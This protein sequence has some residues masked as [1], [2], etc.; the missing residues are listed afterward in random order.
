MGA[1]IALHGDAVK[2]VAFAVDNCRAMHAAAVA[3]GAE[4]VRAPVEL[5][6]AADGSEGSGSVWVATIKTY[7]DCTH[8]FVERAAGFTGAFLPGFRSLAA[9]AAA[10]PLV[11]LTEPIGLSHV[12]HCV[13]NQPDLE[14]TPV[15]DWYERVLQFHRFWS[16]DDKMVHTEF[17]SLRSIVMV[18]YDAVVKMPINEPADGKR[19]SQ[20]QEYVEYHGGAGVQHI[21][22]R[23][24]DI[25]GAVRRL[26]AR[27]VQFL[28]IPAAYYK[29]LRERLAASKCVVKEDMDVIEQ[30]HILVDFDDNGYLLQLFTKPVEDRPTLFIEVIQRNN[31]E[32]F[33]AGNFGALFKSIE[34]EQ[35]RRGNL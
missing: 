31:H 12:D 2:D 7:G 35:D 23:T 20:I 33:G 6:A 8:T 10:D 3:R 34:L 13:G 5:K 16:V 18:D 27:G 4:S 32:G 25:I 19:K 11:K 29:D 9:A 24:D 21:A 22:L 26:R 17:S 1:D 14:M 15:C 30:L 28:T